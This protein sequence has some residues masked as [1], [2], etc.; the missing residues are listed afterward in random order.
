MSVDPSSVADRL[1]PHRALRS[2]H[3]LERHS[4]GRAEALLADARGGA[5][6]RF[7]RH[8]APLLVVPEAPL[9]LRARLAIRARTGGA[10]RTRADLLRRRGG[11]RGTGGRRRARCRCAGRGRRRCARGR[12]TFAATSGRERS[13][14][15]QRGQATHTKVGRHRRMV[16]RRRT[17]CKDAARPAALRAAPRASRALMAPWSTRD[18]RSQSPRQSEIQRP[19]SAARSSRRSSG[20]AQGASSRS[21]SCSSSARP[22]TLRSSGARR[23]RPPHERAQ[24]RRSR[25]ARSA[26]RARSSRTST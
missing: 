3:R 20:S 5:A 26:H 9:H 6:A 22:T 21:S 7:V 11:R 13:D 16:A 18:P 12:A 10:R 24:L 14:E 4:L 15:H 1:P 2:R 23:P 17:S 19:R 25:A 8:A